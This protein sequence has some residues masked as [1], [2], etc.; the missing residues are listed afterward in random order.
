MATLAPRRRRPGP[1][2]GFRRSAR[3]LEAHPGDRAIVGRG[4]ELR[5]AHARSELDIRLIFD[6]ATADVLQCRARQSEGLEAEIALWKRAETRDLEAYVA[7]E[8]N[9][10]GAG[11]DEI[12]LEAGKHI[13]ERTVPARM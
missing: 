12:A 2:R 4:D 9:P 3:V 10:N 1:P 8:A 7:A 6:P 13:F 5:H 11:R